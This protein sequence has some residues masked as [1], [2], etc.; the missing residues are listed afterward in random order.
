MIGT[1]PAFVSGF[2]SRHQ[3]VQFGDENRAK[4]FKTQKTAEKFIA[5]YGDMGYGMSASSVDVIEIS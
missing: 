4:R 1:E 2:S 3:C 5:N